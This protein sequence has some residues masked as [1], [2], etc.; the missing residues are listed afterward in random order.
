MPHTTGS[1]CRTTPPTTPRPR[2]ATGKRS[3]PCTAPTWADTEN[4]ATRRLGAGRLPVRVHCGVRRRKAGA[5]RTHRDRIPGERDRPDHGR[6]ADHRV[7]VARPRAVA[8]GGGCRWFTEWGA[9]RIGRIE[10][11]GDIQT[12]AL[13]DRA[14]EPHGIAVGPDGAVWAAL[15]TGSIARLTTG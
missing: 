2:P 6:R 15:E 10:A 4:R 12:F 13:P 7:P 5:V 11:N 14:C 9:G 3:A 8:D 1:R